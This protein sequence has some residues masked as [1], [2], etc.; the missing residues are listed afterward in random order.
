[1]FM[2]Y[3]LN[4]FLVSHSKAID[5]LR[6]PTTRDGKRIRAPCADTLGT[7]VVLGRYAS[8][9][10]GPNLLRMIVE[11]QMESARMHVHEINHRPVDHR[12]LY[13]PIKLPVI[14]MTDMIGEDG[15]MLPG[16]GESIKEN[17]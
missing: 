8:E 9:S 1:M 10:G 12:Q 6:R 13:K 17:P 2:T 5:Q 16:R 14:R 7:R 4:V 11:A 3:Y 15:Q